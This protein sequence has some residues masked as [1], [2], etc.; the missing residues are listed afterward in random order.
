MA[1]KKKEE[2][3]KAAYAVFWHG[4]GYEFDSEE[5]LLEYLNGEVELGNSLDDMTIFAVGEIF[6]PKVA[7]V[8][9]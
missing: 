7:V 1:K 2:K 3:K 8:L 5:E 6:N 9:R 4:D